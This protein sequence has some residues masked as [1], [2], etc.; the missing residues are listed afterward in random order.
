MISQQPSIS[1]L[2]KSRDKLLH[3]KHVA[4]RYWA[5]ARPKPGTL[6][7]SLFQLLLYSYQQSPFK[8]HKITLF[9]TEQPW[10]QG[11]RNTQ[12]DSAKAPS[13][14][15]DRK[16]SDSSS[17]YFPSICLAVIA[18]IVGMKKGRRDERQL[19]YTVRSRW[20]YWSWRIFIL[21]CYKLSEGDSPASFYCEVA[22]LSVIR[23]MGK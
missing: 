4:N 18:F 2:F 8:M 1:H 5:A 12:Q 20:R 11:F 22:K 7:L 19:M 10:Y 6:Y 23:L 3:S 16:N 9:W 13:L 14:D 17:D 21:V 15:S